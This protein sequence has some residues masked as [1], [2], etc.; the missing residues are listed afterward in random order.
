MD[1]HLIDQHE[2][3]AIRGQHQLGFDHQAR[4]NRPLPLL[5]PRQLRRLLITLLQ[6]L[7]QRHAGQQVGHRPRL[8]Q[9]SIF[10]ITLQAAAA[11]LGVDQARHQ[12]ASQPGGVAGIGDQVMTGLRGI[13]RHLGIDDGAGSNKRLRQLHIDFQPVG[14]DV[15]RGPLRTETGLRRRF[16]RAASEHQQQRCRD[17]IDGTFHCSNGVIIC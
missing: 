7:L 4:G 2:T 11:H 1:L 17:Y 13:L 15:G 9:R 5:E 14:M 6:T 3:A 12:Q 8:L 10:R 16:L